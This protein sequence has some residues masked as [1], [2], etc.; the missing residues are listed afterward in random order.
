[1]SKRELAEMDHVRLDRDRLDKENVKLREQLRQ[2]ALALSE[3]ADLGRWEYSSEKSGYAREFHSVDGR[4]G[5]IVASRALADA[6]IKKSVTG[7]AAVVVRSSCDK[8]RR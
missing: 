4:H 2:T 5:W 7:Y 3:Y 1:M 6:G 8:E